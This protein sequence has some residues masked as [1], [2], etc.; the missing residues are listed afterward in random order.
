MIRTL[1]LLLMLAAPVSAAAEEADLPFFLPTPEGWKTETI[2]FPLNFAP[3][4]DYEGLEELRFA[5]GMFDSTAADFWTYT[6]VWWVEADGFPTKE[7]LEKEL[8]AYWD[9][10][11][12]VVAP[13][14]GFDM[15]DHQSVVKLQP[16][17]NKIEGE[18]GYYGKARI[19]EAF[20]TGQPLELSLS[21]WFDQCEEQEA[22][23]I[24]FEVSPQP[25]SHEVWETMKSIRE[26]FACGTHSGAESGAEE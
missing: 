13:G 12:R 25:K 9:G 11:A 10:L 4:L 3:E 15:G 17:P 21:I 16:F 7:Q 14:K 6:F 8:V 26:G 23:V 24:H 5:P 18:A 1:L 22:R 19:F 20:A 2:P